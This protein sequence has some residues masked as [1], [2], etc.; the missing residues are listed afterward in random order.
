MLQSGS[1]NRHFR[2]NSDIGIVV[3]LPARVEGLFV[4]K[5]HLSQAALA[6]DLFAARNL[7]I[8]SLNAVLRSGRFLLSVG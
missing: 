8:A 6:A 5:V 7:I 2:T 1:A 4:A 3:S